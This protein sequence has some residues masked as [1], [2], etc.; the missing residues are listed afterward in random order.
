MAEGDILQVLLHRSAQPLEAAP[1]GVELA[2]G[3]ALERED[4]L[5]LV[6]D[7]EDRAGGRTRAGPNEKLAGQRLDDP[8][9]PRARVLCLVD[10]HVID[11]EVELVVDPRR[12]DAL[13]ERKRAIDQVVI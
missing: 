7:G 9:L 8:T 5:L 12:F 11:A 2:R 4:R 13:E 6:A 1:H 3:G 10:Q